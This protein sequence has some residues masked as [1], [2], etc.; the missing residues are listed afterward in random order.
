ML[1]T[2]GSI[3][4]SIPTSCNMFHFQPIFSILLM[5]LLAFPKYRVDSLAHL[6]PGQPAPLLFVE[7]EV[8]TLICSF[9]GEFTK[10]VCND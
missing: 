6:M 8:P 7:L 10:T 1:R 9:G 5:L 4:D 2:G 3:S